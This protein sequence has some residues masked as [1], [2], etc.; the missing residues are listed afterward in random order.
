MGSSPQ[1]P[2]GLIQDGFTIFMFY[3]KTADTGGKAFGGGK[4]STELLRE[5][6]GMDVE[7]S[8]LEYYLKQ[9]YYTHQRQ[10]ICESSYRRR[11]ICYSY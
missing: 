10:M 2:T 5:Y 7:E 8:T 1:T 11:W 3:P 6:L 4:G 9:G